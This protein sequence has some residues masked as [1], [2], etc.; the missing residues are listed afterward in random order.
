MAAT[1]PVFTDEEFPASFSSISPTQA[2]QGKNAA[3]V[4]KRPLEISSK[5]V[6]FN[7][8]VSGSPV[9]GRLGDWWFVGAMA[10]VF[11]RR[12]EIIVR[13]FGRTPDGG[14][15]VNFSY[16]GHP[17]SIKVDDQIPCST[18]TGRPIFASSTNE[19]EFWPCIVEKAY[20]KLRG[21]YEAMSKGTLADGFVDIAG[22]VPLQ[23]NFADLGGAP[24]IAAKM[25]Y[26]LSM[27][28]IVTATKATA[29]SFN[30]TGVNE[31]YPYV[32]EAVS[33]VLGVPL[34][35]VWNQ[36]Q[37]G[38][39][40]G[41]W[42]NCS[43]KWTPELRT[44]F[45]ISETTIDSF[46]LTPE[47]F[48]ATFD[49]FDV[50]CVSPKEF[51]TEGDWKVESAGGCSNHATWGNNPQYSLS[52]GEECAVAISLAQPAPAQTLINIGFTVHGA[53]AIDT[54]LP[55]ATKTDLACTSGTFYNK[56]QV[57]GEFVMQANKPYVLVPCT[58]EP[59]TESHFILRISAAKPLRLAVI[60]PASE[61]EPPVVVMVKCAS[62]G[63]EI[64]EFFD[65]RGTKLCSKCFNEKMCSA[66]QTR[67][68]STLRAFK[69]YEGKFYHTDCFRCKKCNSNLKNPHVIDGALY[70]DDCSRACKLCH[71]PLY[72]SPSVEILDDVYHRSCVKCAKCSV[73][74]DPDE[75]VAVVE[76]AFYC[77]TCSSS[78]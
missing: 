18:A 23:V 77:D 30:T 72:I 51:V 59:G 68:P 45:G 63:C 6:L 20:A 39:W 61:A 8:P 49:H 29:L 22:G 52:C 7:R 26:Y 48:V 38:D 4:W 43:P 64:S 36:W 32:V 16:N 14:Y 44:K 65:N 41:E 24:Q 46:C 27:N 62:C 13:M 66:C 47:E 75:G 35:K 53:N 33:D 19:N 42:S 70:C 21:S 71:K 28:W 2:A 78:L 37:R 73:A 54:L 1:A 69:T 17:V 67:I 3:I 40:E 76:G 55:K 5:A 15:T 11:C 50:C 34:I 56:R 60:P 57:G 31:G 12:K 25:K 74:L 58:F 9:L 10:A